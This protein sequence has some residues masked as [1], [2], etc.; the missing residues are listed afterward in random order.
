MRL[1]AFFCIL[2]VSVFSLAEEDTAFTFS[3]M[4]PLGG[5][6]PH[7]VG[8]SLR[9]AHGSNHYKWMVA[10]KFLENGSF[11]TGVTIQAFPEVREQ[12]GKPA[13][14]FVHES[15]SSLTDNAR[16]LS[17][18]TSMEAGIFERICSESHET[19]TI[20]SITEEYRIDYSGFWNDEIDLGVIVIFGVPKARF[21]KYEDVFEKMSRI[22]LIDLERFRDDT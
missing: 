15:I 18:C 9:E 8:W 1:V 13:S 6:V 17:K 4:E 3:I 10:E 16:V 5:T 11:S 21:A 14:V 20:N 19:L 12:V 22:T 2:F 7:P